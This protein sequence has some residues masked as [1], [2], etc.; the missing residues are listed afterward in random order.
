[1]MMMDGMTAMAME[2]ATGTE[3]ANG[4]H[5]GDSNGRRDGNAAAMMTM[6]GTTTMQQQ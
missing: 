1:M 6:D 2:T 4:W 3:M 5:N